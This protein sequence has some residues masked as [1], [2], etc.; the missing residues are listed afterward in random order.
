M[1]PCSQSR[2]IDHFLLDY[3]CILL[4]INVYYL[5]HGDKEIIH[6]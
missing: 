6:P 4:I 1:D 2:D 5:N 3:D